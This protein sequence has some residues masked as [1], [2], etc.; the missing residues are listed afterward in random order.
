[1]SKPAARKNDPHL[2]PMFSGT[3]PHVG[4]PAIAGS[5]TVLINNLP[6][7]R[8]GDATICT[9]VGCPDPLASAASTV[10]IENL[11]A[12]RLGDLTIHGGCIVAGSPDVFIGN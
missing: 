3:T 10:L 11:G 7:L 1:M 9:G 4:G 12:G 6:A 5:P 8:L 2:C